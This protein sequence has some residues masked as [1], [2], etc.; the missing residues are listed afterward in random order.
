[1]KKTI[2]ML[3]ALVLLFCTVSAFV[4]CEIGTQGVQGLPGEQGP[5]GEQ[6]N[7]GETGRGILKTEIIDGCLWITYTDDPNNPVNVGSVLSEDTGSDCLLYKLNDDGE[8]CS[9]VGLENCVET[10][11]IIPA[12]FKQKPVTGIAASAFAGFSL[13]KSITIPDSITSI[14]AYAFEGCSSLTSITIPDS[15]INIAYTAFNDCSSLVRFT[16]SENNETYCAIDGILYN[17]L[18]TKIIHIP[19]KIS[20]DVIILEGVTKID[21]SA[22]SGRSSLTSITIPDSVTSISYSAFSGCSSLISITIPDSVTSISSYA[23][24]GCSSLTS[25]KI[26]DSVISID[27]YA[28]SD[29]SGLISI[30][31]P[32]SVTSI[33]YSAFSGCS[34]LTSI[35]IPFVGATKEWTSNNRHFGYIFGDSSYFQNNKHIPTSLKTVVITGGIDIFDYAFYNCSSLTSITIPEGVYSIYRYAFASCSSLT[36]ITI[37]DSVTNIYD[38]AFASCSSLTSITFEGTVARWNAIYHDT[39]KYTIYCTDGTIAKDGIIT[40]Y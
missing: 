38:Y 39:E 2:S 14:G 28:F 7:Q 18:E 30:T 15:V 32:D 10:E 5:Q 24:S 6:G 37:P 1:M 12:K 26:P 8:T 13:L 9:V 17:K 29:C 40:Y 21:N 25:V 23:F 35:T 3:L 31:I 33:G 4:S 34:N 11:L 36:S 20:G 19:Q 16:V 27:T 22:F